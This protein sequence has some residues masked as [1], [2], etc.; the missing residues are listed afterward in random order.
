MTEERFLSDLYEELM[1]HHSWSFEASIGETLDHDVLWVCRGSTTKAKK[2]IANWLK[3]FENIQR[4]SE[5]EEHFQILQSVFNK[6]VDFQKEP[7]FKGDGSFE[8]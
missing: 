3:S 4:S 5:T 2:I 8:I 1:S 7:Y 6:I